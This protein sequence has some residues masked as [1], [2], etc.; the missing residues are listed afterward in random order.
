MVL[1]D[2]ADTRLE[3]QAID[4]D[5]MQASTRTGTGPSLS[6]A[7]YNMGLSTIIGNKER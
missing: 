2:N 6:L 5:R 7:R 3:W 4:K 1:S